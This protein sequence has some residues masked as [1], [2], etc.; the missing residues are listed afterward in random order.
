MTRNESAMGVL[1]SDCIVLGVKWARPY[2]GL[3]HGTREVVAAL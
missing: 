3:L 1:F 2:H